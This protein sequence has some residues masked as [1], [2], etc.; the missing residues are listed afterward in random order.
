MIIR[1]KKIISDIGHI[2]SCFHNLCKKSGF[3]KEIKKDFVK[4]EAKYKEWISRGIIFNS[5]DECYLQVFC[6]SNLQRK[7][8][9]NIVLYFLYFHNYVQICVN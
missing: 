9:C 1:G 3:W 2:S 4:L 8:F 5:S 6:P 7:N